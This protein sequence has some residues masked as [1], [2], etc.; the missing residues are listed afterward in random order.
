M[1]DPVDHKHFFRV[2]GEKDPATG[3]KSYTDYAVKCEDIEVE[4]LGDG[5][6]ALYEGGENSLSYSSRAR[7]KK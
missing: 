1:Y 6:L 7:G 3:R 4:L 5:F 2:Y